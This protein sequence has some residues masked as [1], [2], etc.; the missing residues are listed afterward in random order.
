MKYTAKYFI[1]KFSK[2]PDDKWCMGKY[3]DGYACCALGH[4][5]A[6]NTDPTTRETA[7]LEALFRRLGTSAPSINDVR[8]LSPGIEPSHL[9]DTPKERVI[10]ALL[11]IAA[12]VDIN[13]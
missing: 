12:G 5:G 4:C 10:D 9:G 13:E 2:I 11:L 3:T 1:N 6:T 8:Y 7:H